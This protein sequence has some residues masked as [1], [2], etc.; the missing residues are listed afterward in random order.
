MS[1]GECP[2]PR[3]KKYR[4]LDRILGERKTK[5][6]DKRQSGSRWPERWA[7][8]DGEIISAVF[9]MAS[10]IVKAERGHC[11]LVNIAVFTTLHYFFLKRV[12]LQQVLNSCYCYC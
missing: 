6:V 1:R 9:C 10:S 5:D 2:I 7:G 11:L 3:G 12:Y 4:G 8:Q